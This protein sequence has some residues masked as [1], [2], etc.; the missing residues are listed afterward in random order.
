MKAV[1][2]K[3]E[4][5]Y[6]ELNSRAICINV[7][8]LNG[9][10]RKQLDILQTFLEYLEFYI[11]AFW[12]WI[13]PKSCFTN[14]IPRGSCLQI[15]CLYIKKCIRFFRYWLCVRYSVLRSYLSFLELWSLGLCFGTSLKIQMQVLYYLF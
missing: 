10:N 15:G 2:I 6:P 4:P 8:T 12:G 1:F 11:V 9:V 5:S 3:T 7:K 14:Y 13:N